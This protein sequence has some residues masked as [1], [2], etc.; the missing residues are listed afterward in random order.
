MHKIKKSL[1]K[2]IIANIIF[3]ICYFLLKNYT[4]WVTPVFAGMT[5]FLLLKIIHSD[6]FK[7][8]FTK[9]RYSLSL[10]KLLLCLFVL[11]ERLFGKKAG[12]YLFSFLVPASFGVLQ[13]KIPIIVFSLI[14]IFIF[15]ITKK[16]NHFDRAS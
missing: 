12:S 6:F 9:K 10:I 14:G 5:S 7:F 15:L 11:F 16:L 8:V 3:L 2:I 1:K 13:K 4:D